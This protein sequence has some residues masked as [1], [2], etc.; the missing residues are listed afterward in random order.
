MRIK[1]L[2]WPTMERIEEIQRGTAWL[3]TTGM[4]VDVLQRSAGV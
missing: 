1:E 2:L 3:M 4:H